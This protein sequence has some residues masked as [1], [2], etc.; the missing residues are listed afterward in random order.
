MRAEAIPVL[1][2]LA[3]AAPGQT[4]S[5]SSGQGP[6]RGPLRERA[7]PDDCFVGPA[8]AATRGSP[9]RRLVASHAVA[10]AGV[11]PALAVGLSVSFGLD[12]SRWT[13][14][15]WINI[16]AFVGAYLAAWLVARR[17]SMLTASSSI[18]ATSMA[19]AGVL[20]MA[21]F[22]ATRSYYSLSFLGVAFAIGSTWMVVLWHAS[23]RFAMPTLAVVPGG[24]VD[25]L[26][27]LPGIRL[28]PLRRPP[29]RTLPVDG[30]VV[31][32][33]APHAAEWHRFVIDRGIEGTPIHHC[34][35][36][37]ERFAQKVSIVHLR[38]ND[39]DQ[40]VPP[41]YAAFKRVVDVIG[42]VIGLVAAAPVLLLAAWLIRREDRGPALFAQ[43]RVGHRGERFMMLKLRSMRPD[44]EADGPRLAVEDDARATRIGAV[45]RRWR[46]DELPQLWNVLRGEMS[47]V[48]PRP[49]QVA[50]VRRFEEEL[51][52]Y[53]A[54]HAVKPGIT[55]WAQ[56]RAG[57]AGDLP[58]TQQKLVHDL[59]YV[60]NMSPWLD[61]YI[62]GRT[63]WIVLSGFGAR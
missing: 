31:D 11:L 27:G 30:I 59:Y 51:P 5:P 62:V 37:Y 40:P 33:H 13:S 39:L 42:A 3:G 20:V 21:G 32:R 44:A 24:H 43:E 50:F 4:A 28:L 52:F 8:P 19:A 53:A 58:E 14:G 38:E 46:I 55:G 48:G 56:V 47:L 6:L 61:A 16:L 1:P 57:Y 2:G 54:R 63:A 45:L 34:A 35:D 29:T 10:L 49:E 15:Q 36:V 18:A 9:W 23:Q 60:R 41:P 12:P 22:F 25:I 7:I 17:S 26:D